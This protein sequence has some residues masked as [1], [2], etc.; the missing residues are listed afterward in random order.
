MAAVYIREGQDEEYADNRFQDPACH[1][2]DP[3]CTDRSRFYSHFCFNVYYRH[4]HRQQYGQLRND[5]Y[6]SFSAADFCTGNLCAVFLQDQEN[7]GVGDQRDGKGNQI[8]PDLWFC[9][10]DDLHY[11][12]CDCYQRRHS[13]DAEQSG[14][15]IGSGQ[16]QCRAVCIRIAGRKV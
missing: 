15:C 6:R 1:G 4:Q 16:Q 2:D 14:L 11:C 13:T 3:A 7:A 10:S 8:M 9:D 12:S 5:D